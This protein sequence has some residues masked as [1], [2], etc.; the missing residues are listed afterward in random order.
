MRLW[1]LKSDL[2]RLDLLPLVHCSTPWNLEESSNRGGTG[3]ASLGELRASSAIKTVG[4]EF[5]VFFF[6]CSGLKNEEL[7]L[8]K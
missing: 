5:E 8:K 6:F 7:L 4:G 2:E 1:W 3:E